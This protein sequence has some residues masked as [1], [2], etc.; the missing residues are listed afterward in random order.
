M[1]N[2]RFSLEEFKALFAGRFESEDQL[3]REYRSFQAVF[4]HLDSMTVPDLSRVQK[5]EIF[6]RSW[7]AGRRGRLRVWPILF[8]QPVVTFAAGIVL[9][10]TLMFT[11]VHVRADR[12]Q[13][14]TVDQRVRMV[15]P[16]AADRMLTVERMRY[17]QVYKGKVVQRLYPQIENPKIVVEKAEGSSTPQRV[18]YGTLDEGEVYIVWNL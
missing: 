10:C 3:L 17:T 1:D 8:R 4:E 12:S 6:Q 9:G 16:P 7:R 5:A 15:A 2:K 18:L 13:P 14:P 11:V